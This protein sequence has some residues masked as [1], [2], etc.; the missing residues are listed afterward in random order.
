MITDK[1]A[2]NT[3]AVAQ[4]P[5]IIEGGGGSSNGG[6]YTII[7]RP[8]MPALQAITYVPPTEIA[9]STNQVPATNTP[10]QG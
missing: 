7:H 8:E 3:A 10:N 1:C 5:G 2:E 6:N 9:E 4:S